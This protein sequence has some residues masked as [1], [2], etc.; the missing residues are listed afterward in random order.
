[1]IGKSGVGF[2]DLSVSVLFQGRDVEWSEEG[3]NGRK[4][5]STIIDEWY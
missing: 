4:L 2:C 1:M 5:I 3:T